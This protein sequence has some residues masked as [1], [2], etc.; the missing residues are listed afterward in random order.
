MQ[1]V[2]IDCCKKKNTTAAMKAVL[3]GMVAAMKAVV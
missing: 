3:K 1:P 2:G